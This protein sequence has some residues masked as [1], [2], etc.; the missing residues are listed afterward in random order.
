MF[1]NL[2]SPSESKLR[3]EGEGVYLREAQKGDYQAWA[4]LRAASE[5]W[6]VPWEPEW[7]FDEL[8]RACYLWR[9]QGWRHDIKLGLAAPFL[10]F[11]SSDDALVGG[12]NISNIRRG[13]AQ[14]CT[15]GYWVGQPFARQGFTRAAVRAVVAYAFGPLGLHRVQAACVPTNFRSRGLLESIGFQEEGLARQ[16]LKINGEW[17]DQAKGCRFAAARLGLGNQ[18]FAQQGRRQA[19]RL[20]GGHAAV[21]QLFE[22]VQD[23]RRQIERPEVVGRKGCCIHRRDYRRQGSRPLK[24]TPTP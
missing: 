3:L 13:V 1:L 19:G 6:L 9:L 22:V 5:S 16:Y 15:I 18:V 8:S 20:D 10:V 2:V 4:D 21:P 17:K 24:A 7:R 11:R 12:V 23:G 14:D